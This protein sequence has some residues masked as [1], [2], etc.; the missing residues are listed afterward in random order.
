MH[1]LAQG[2][3]KKYNNWDWSDDQRKTPQAFSHFTWEVGAPAR[4]NTRMHRDAFATH[5]L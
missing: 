4:T 1:V 2:D 5:T 3:Y